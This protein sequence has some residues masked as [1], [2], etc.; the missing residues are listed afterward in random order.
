MKKTS[1]LLATLSLI[2]CALCFGGCANDKGITTYKIDCTLTD[3][4]LIATQTV[5]FFNHSE[6]ALSVIK[7]NLYLLLKGGQL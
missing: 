6:N 4:E 3:K 7:F 5:D 1:I 2:V